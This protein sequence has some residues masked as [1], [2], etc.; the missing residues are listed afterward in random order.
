METAALLTLGRLRGLEVAAVLN[1]VVL[2]GEDVQQG[3]NQYV[4]ADS[5]MMQGEKLASLAA[6]EALCC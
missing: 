2:Y 5:A 3:I 6:L 4:D 1:N